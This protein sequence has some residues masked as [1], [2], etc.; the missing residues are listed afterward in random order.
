M[1]MKSARERKTPT[2]LS[3]RAELV[4]RARALQ[5]NLSELFEKALVEAIAA[6]EREIWLAENRDAIEEYNAG[7]G[8]RGVFSDDWRRF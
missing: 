6:R 1:R 8:E 4:R 2:N 7:V 5:L 3:V